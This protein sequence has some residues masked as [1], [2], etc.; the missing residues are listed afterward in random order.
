SRN[1]SDDRQL[2]VGQLPILDAGRAPGLQWQTEL[3]CQPIDGQQVRARVELR[4]AT[5][6][7]LG[8]TALAHHRA[9]CDTLAPLDVR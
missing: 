1:R 8:C 3:P 7:L 4:D 6:T 9:G 5:G 2:F